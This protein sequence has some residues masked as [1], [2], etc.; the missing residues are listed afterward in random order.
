MPIEDK[1]KARIDQAQ[2]RSYYKPWFRR[3][4]GRVATVLGVILILVV[5]YFLYLVINNIWHLKRGEFY[6][7]D[8]NT[9]ISQVEF[10]KN[11]QAVAELMTD[12]DPWLGSEEPLVYVAAF[13]SFA[14]PYCQDSQADIK[15]M[16][17]E[18]GGLVRFVTKDF[19]TE[20]LHPNVFDAHLAAACADE[21]GRYWEYHDLLYQNQEHFDRDNLKKLASQVG[22]NMNQ[23]NECLTSEKY[24]QEIREDYS[25]GVQA[26]IQGTPSYLIN[27]N[28]IPGQ[29]PLDVWK[30]IIGFILKE[31]Y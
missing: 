26:G 29:I 24:A 31:G 18:F 1:I 27:G 9:W 8:T 15:T 16:L 6:S 25:D 22:I 17:A 11:Q 13:E 28:L 4:W 14:C 19:P 10:E 12:D 20:G 21:Q 2:V 23:F 30:D 7:I 3:G 5:L